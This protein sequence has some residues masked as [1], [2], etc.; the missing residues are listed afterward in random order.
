MCWLPVPVH[1]G[2]L[3]SWRIASLVVTPIEKTPEIAS[4][5]R[6]IALKVPQLPGEGPHS[7][8]MLCS[9][10]KFSMVGDTPRPKA[11]EGGHFKLFCFAFSKLPMKHID[12]QRSYLD[13]WGT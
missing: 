4:S 5:K 2:I 13:F 1:D 11:M 6:A 10:H 9:L 3:G 7:C 8:D 12:G